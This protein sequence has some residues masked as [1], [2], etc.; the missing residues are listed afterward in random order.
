MT[1][2]DFDT[3]Y[4]AGSGFVWKLNTTF[5]KK[6]GFFSGKMKF[7]TALISNCG[8]RSRRL[9]YLKE[10][11]NYVPIDIYGRCRVKR[12]QKIV[13]DRE[14]P[15]QEIIAKKY[16]LFFAFE[17]SICKDYITEKFFTLLKF[18]IVPIVLGGGDYSYFVPRSAYI[19]VLDFK[20]PRQLAMFLKKVKL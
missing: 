17:N 5:L 10:M 15:C 4:E 12:L 14:V 9:D 20:S 11:Q 1:D 8:T 7:C 18:D 2:S 19:N 13:N 3:P 16:K 6:F